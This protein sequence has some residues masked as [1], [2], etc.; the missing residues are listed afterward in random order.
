MRRLL[1]LPFYLQAKFLRAL[2]AGL[3]DRDLRIL[4]S[5]LVAWDVTCTGNLSYLDMMHALRLSKIVVMDLTE[6]GGHVPSQ[7]FLPF[8]LR[9]CLLP[10]AEQHTSLFED[11]FSRQIDLMRKTT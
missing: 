11:L 1:K 2:D 10:A 8:Y 6:A 9:S 5:Y 3:T 4:M 7:V